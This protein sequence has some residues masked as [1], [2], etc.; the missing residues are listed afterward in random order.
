MLAMELAQQHKDNPQDDIVNVLLNGTVEDEPLDEM[1]FCNFFLM[2]I[3]AG[4]ETT[5]NATAHGMRLLIDHP[6]QYQMLVDDPGL[7]P[8]AV[9]EILR[10]NP[11]V[12][13]FRR[14]AMEDTHIGEQPVKKGRQ[15]CHVLRRCEL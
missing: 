1:E 14:T 7:V 11:P 10:Y 4:I 13:A 2:L 6:E 12:I 3:V 15:D 9:E 5:R 8:D